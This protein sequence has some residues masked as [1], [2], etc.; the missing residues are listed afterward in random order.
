MSENDNIEVAPVASKN[1]YAESMRDFRQLD[2][3]AKTSTKEN[4]TKK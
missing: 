2:V 1:R 4:G 3:V